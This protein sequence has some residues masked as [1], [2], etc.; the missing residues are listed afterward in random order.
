MYY[1]RLATV[2]LMNGVLYYLQI[3]NGSLVLHTR[4]PIRLTVGKVAFGIIYLFCIITRYKTKGIYLP[5]YQNE[6]VTKPKVLDP[7]T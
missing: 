1:V 6:N 7:I 2:R 5:A 4:N 3:P